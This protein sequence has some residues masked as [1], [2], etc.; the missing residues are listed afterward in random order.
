[1]LHIKNYTHKCL[2]L[3][4]LFLLCAQQRHDPAAA[5]P[6]SSLRDKS[7]HIPLSLS[8]QVTSWG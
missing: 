7:A 1:M 8:S 2:P 3:T 5:S 6:T 4:N